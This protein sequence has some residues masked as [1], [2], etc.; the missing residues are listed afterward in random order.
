MQQCFGLGTVRSKAQKAGIVLFFYA[1]HLVTPTYLTLTSLV[2]PPY[3]R[4]PRVTMFALLH[5]LSK[6][7]ESFSAAA[8]IPRHREESVP[9]FLENLG[10]AA[11]DRS[12]A[13][14]P[15]VHQEF[16]SCNCFLRKVFCDFDHF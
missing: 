2:V 6:H 3:L 4:Q 7:V 14:L 1:G 5:F 8:Q 15:G 10:Y 9:L 16:M 12:N 13:L 11:V